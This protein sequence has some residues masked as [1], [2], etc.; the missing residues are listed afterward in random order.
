MTQRV[1]G[2]LVP[3]GANA[4]HVKSAELA[5]ERRKKK[6]TAGKDATSPATGGLGGDMQS[7]LV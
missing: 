6:R 2:F 3:G 4:L 1:L 7:D 5:Q